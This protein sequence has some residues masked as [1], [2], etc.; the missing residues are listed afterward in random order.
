MKHALPLLIGALLGSGI[1]Y[2]IFQGDDPIEKSTYQPYHTENQSS[3]QVM[4]DSSSDPFGG[5]SNED[6]SH[7]LGGV[8]G[9]PWNTYD[10][11]QNGGKSNHGYGQMNMGIR[12]ERDIA[13]SMWY[14]DQGLL[15]DNLQVHTGHRFKKQVGKL[16]AGPVEILE[17]QLAFMKEFLAESERLGRIEDGQ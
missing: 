17:E 1:T 11:S 9:S 8:E 7:M 16:Y 6:D 5:G 14:F 10:P 13:I 12:F 4:E 3:S 2:Y 15:S